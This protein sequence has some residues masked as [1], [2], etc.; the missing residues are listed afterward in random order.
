[1][2]WYLILLIIL[3]SVIGLFGFIFL[4]GR[5]TKS[6]FKNAKKYLSPKVHIETA[7]VEEKKVEEVV[8]SK[9]GLN[10]ENQFSD[11]EQPYFE[12][13][14]D[15]EQNFEGMNLDDYKINKNTKTKSLLEQIRELSPELKMLIF[16]RGLARKEYDF[17]SKKD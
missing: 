15:Q 10:F 9:I 8:A 14:N 17:K 12:D 4:L 1:M 13:E 2:A 6:K 11:D 16:D 5:L 3:A 7:P